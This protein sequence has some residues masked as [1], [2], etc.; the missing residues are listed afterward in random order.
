MEGWKVGLGRKEGHTNIR[1]SAKLGI[2]L[3]ILWSESRDLTNCANHA[4]P[5]YSIKMT[6]TMTMTMAYLCIL[7]Q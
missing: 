4:R 6:M 2:E 7:L 3:E 1:I 5:F